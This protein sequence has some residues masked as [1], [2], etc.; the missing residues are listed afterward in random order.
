[1]LH[2]SLDLLDAKI[3]SKAEQAIALMDADPELKKLGASGV[4]VSE[5]ARDLAIQMAYYS[6]GRMKS[7]DVK[8]MYSAVGLYPI[9]D[10]EAN[11]PIAW[12]LKSKHIDGMAV[13]LVPKRNNLA[14]WTAPR[15]VWE[16]MGVLGESVGLSWGGR[17]KNSDC[18]HFEV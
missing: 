1:M 2:N 9:R 15:T 14:W 12:T 16:R 4:M 8:A 7:P 6:R 11:K 13:D 17:W 10:D 5:T 3:K 18:P